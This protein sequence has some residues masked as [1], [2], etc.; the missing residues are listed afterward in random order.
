MNAISGKISFLLILGVLILS[1]IFTIDPTSSEAMGEIK[2]FVFDAS[3]NAPLKNAYVI[4]LDYINFKT[5]IIRTNDDGFFT[6]KVPYGIY[7]IFAVY[8]NPTTPG[9]DYIPSYALNASLESPAK[10]NYEHPVIY[11]NFSLIPAAS[12]LL[13]GFIE[14]VGGA[15][16]GY[17]SVY[18]IDSFGKRVNLRALYP[19]IQGIPLS[20]YGNSEIDFMYLVEALHEVFSSENL[21]L[22]P[23]NKD[24]YLLFSAMVFDNRI[25]GLS[26]FNFTI[27]IGE[28]PINLPKGGFTVI[29]Y[30]KTA[31]KQLI[32][33]IRSDVNFAEGLLSEAEGLGF[34]IASEREDLRA[35]INSINYA[36]NMIEQGDYLRALLALGEV[37]AMSRHI[38]VRRL[39]YM[40]AVAKAGAYIL[41]S[42]L[43]F[44]SMSMAFFLYEDPRRKMLSFVIIYILSVLGFCVTYPG[45]HLVVS[46][47][48]LQNFV[49]TALACG[50]G[51]LFLVF[52]LPKIFREPELPSEFTKLSV[53]VITFSLAKRYA[54]LRRLRLILTL[55]TIALLIWAFTTLTSISTVYG[56]AIDTKKQEAAPNIQALLFRNIV[57]DSVYQLPYS[58]YSWAQ[59]IASTELVAP[60]AWSD[61]HRSLK[62]TV[63]S[64]FSTYN[65]KSV[66]GIRPSM[67]GSITG[68]KD[69][70]VG[71]RL[72]ADEERRYIIIS[73]DAARRLGV[74]PGDN[75]TVWIQV[76]TVKEEVGNFVV[77]AIL[78]D[79]AL[80]RI[81][82][83]D[84]GYYLPQRYERGSLVVSSPNE[85]IIMSFEDA[86]R[87]PPQDDRGF[88]KCVHIYRIMV[89]LQN[90]KVSYDE[91]AKTIV[92]L[93]GYQVWAVEGNILKHY[94]FGAKVEIRGYQDLLAPLLIVIVNVGIVMYSAVRE[95]QRDVLIFTAVG[96]NPTHLA[97][98]FLAESIVMGLVGGGLGYL[99]GLATFRLFSFLG[100]QYQLNIREKLEWYW[101]II[102]L[103][104]ALSVSIAS[105]LRAAFRAMYLVIPSLKRKIKVKSEEERKEIMT[106]IMRA[107][108]EKRY[109]M[110]LR[111]HEYEEI[112]F[113]GFL[114]DNLRELSTGVIE[115]IEDI[116][117]MPVKEED[118]RKIKLYKFIFRST[119]YGRLERVGAELRLVKESGR[120]YF[121]PQLYARPLTSETSVE[122]LDRLAEI[123]KDICVR[124]TRERSDIVTPLKGRRME[125]I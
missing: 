122:T 51:V 94:Y 38:L 35:A 113:E 114:L 108:S 104:L 50:L 95:R 78:D 46:L 98:L 45:F 5:R 20:R 105:S 42:F 125:G 3:N 99:G 21:V 124:W 57:K 86:V 52:I 44:F 115:R 102:G 83:I 11:T 54:K 2:G 6:V 49:I 69:L 100:P 66:L 111:I 48:E 29:N 116:K 30:T 28:N 82:D 76:G 72:P 31:M 40:Y 27:G 93:R 9:V 13:N 101:S 117:G 33:L 88:S 96:F 58:D 112:F 37:Y 77:K 80:S 123:M 4:I 73:R 84:G 43:A 109:D 74:G 56:L 106:R 18:I 75:V 39:N 67:E 85:V 97:L 10:L 61:P 25:N 71:G 119:R 62:I 68:L 34:Y 47:N 22:V 63:K 26:R 120:D 91:L 19:N 110:P 103:L 121:V 12:I 89:K 53:L 32:S 107:H 118:G 92:Y 14:Y 90:S 15:Y 17:F 8:D 23:A 79:D 36:E 65:F 60:L 59:R 41:P 7:C 55:F 64:A 24:V 87:L 1:I 70:I 16:T 81:K